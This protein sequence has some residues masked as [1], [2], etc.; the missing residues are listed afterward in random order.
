MP[1]KTAREAFVRLIQE[2]KGIII[3]I[4]NSYCHDRNDREDLAQE[5]T[6]QLWRSYRQYKSGYV[7][8]TWMYRVAL[9]VAISF[10]RSGRKNIPVVS[11]EEGILDLAETTDTSGLEEDIGLLQQFIREL[12]ELDRAL[13]LLHL[14]SKNYKEIAEIL[15]ITETNV[16]TRLTRIREKLRKNFEAIKK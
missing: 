4:C 1:E 14:E 3:K 6:Y 16:A 11:L 13:I 7:F 2:N 8:T 9:N 12:K 5:I 15:G 10:Y